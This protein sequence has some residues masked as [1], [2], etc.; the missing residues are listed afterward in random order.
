[1]SVIFRARSHLQALS[2]AV[3]ISGSS[4]LVRTS[5]CLLFALARRL[6]TDSQWWELTA[7]RKRQE[8]VLIALPESEFRPGQ[9]R[10][11]PSSETNP[12]C[13]TGCKVCP[14]RVRVCVV[15]PGAGSGETCG[16]AA[17]PLQ[18]SNLKG[19]LELHYSSTFEAFNLCTTRSAVMNLVTSK[20]RQWVRA[21]CMHD[22]ALLAPGGG[23]GGEGNE[24]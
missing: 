4:V 1:M 16:T 8:K 17:P 5:T 3:A 24:W 20:R 11:L 14:W 12:V 21:C 15:F 19:Y 13:T 6:P 18:L 7:D 23:L 22:C 10:T 2:L 9:R